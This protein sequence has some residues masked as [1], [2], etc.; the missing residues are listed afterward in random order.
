M[1]QR[2]R[3]TERRINRQVEAFERANPRVAEAMKLFGISMQSY[4]RAI[5]ALS[6]AKTITS[7][8]TQSF[9]YG[10]MERHTAGD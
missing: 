1:A 7:N 3:S 2:S 9:S 8:S 6:G 5:Q 10:D 4:A